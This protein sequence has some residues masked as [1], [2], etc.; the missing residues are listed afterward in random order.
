MATSTEAQICNRALLLVGNRARIDDLT[1]NTL[2]AQLCADIFDAARDELLE[3]HPWK[4]ASRAATLALVDDA[5]FPG[6]DLVYALPSDCVKAREIFAG[7]RNPSAEQRIAF[8]TVLVE[9]PGGTPNVRALVTDEADAQLLYT[10]QVNTSGLW[11]PLFCGALAWK[12]AISLAFGLPVKPDVAQ[13]MA[14]G[15]AVAIA[16]AKALDANQAQKD[17]PPPSR[18]ISGR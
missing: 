9:D 12:L 13:R 4:F 1:Q 5:T 8:D 2:E 11:S 16:T 6:W 3:E 7:T 10:A 18:Y 17:A 14:T 15:Y